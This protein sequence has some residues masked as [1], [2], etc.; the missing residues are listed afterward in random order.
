MNFGQVVAA[1]IVGIF[2]AAL[3]SY[4]LFPACMLSVGGTC[5][6]R[7]EAPIVTFTKQLK[8]SVPRLP[9]PTAAAADDY[10][11]IRPEEFHNCSSRNCKLDLCEIGIRNGQFPNV[12]KCM[13]TFGE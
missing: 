12:G 3:I 6:T 1:V 13:Q 10:V 8:A 9:Q 5:L 11:P 4:L 2:A 7:G